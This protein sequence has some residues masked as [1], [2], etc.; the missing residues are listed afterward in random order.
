MRVSTD[1]FIIMQIHT[2]RM[3]VEYEGTRYSGWQKQPHSR[4]IQGEI[5]NASQNFLGTEVH[6]NGSG[7]TDAGV[8]ALRQ[9]ASLRVKLGPK[10]PSIKQLHAGINADLPHDINILKIIPVPPA[11]HPR[12]DAVSRYY[13]YQIAT[14]R[15]AF[16]KPF[17]WWVRDRLDVSEMALGLKL[18]TGRHD[19]SSFSETQDNNTSTIVH[20]HT[21]EIGTVGG[22]ILIRIGASHFLWKMVRRIVG[23]IVE[24]GRGR[25]TSANFLRMLQ[26]SSNEAAALT[27]PPSGLFLEQVLYNNDPPPGAIRPAFPIA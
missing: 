9:V 19:F 16:G 20:V 24:I 15:T 14:R 27:A 8:H 18:I 4:S 11:F 22:L 10:A 26:T 23:T 5:I 6:I 7:R 17:V 3:D 1:R 21:A 2:W 12:H 25:M 13:L